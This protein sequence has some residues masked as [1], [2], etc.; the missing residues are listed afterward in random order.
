MIVV[1]FMTRLYYFTFYLKILLS[2]LCEKIKNDAVG[3]YVIGIYIDCTWEEYE[4]SPKYNK[5]ECEIVLKVPVCIY[6]Y[7]EQI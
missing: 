5:K 4:T 3:T 1:F 2:K 7:G 6:T